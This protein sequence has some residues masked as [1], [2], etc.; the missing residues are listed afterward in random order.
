MGG[1]DYEKNK[2]TILALAVGFV[3]MGVP[4]KADDY[5]VMGVQ[6]AKTAK[7]GGFTTLTLESFGNYD[8][9]GADNVRYAEKELTLGLVKEKGLELLGRGQVKGVNCDAPVALKAG[10]STPSQVLSKTIEKSVSAYS[11]SAINF[12]KRTFKLVKK[13]DPVLVAALEGMLSTSYNTAVKNYAGDRPMEIG[14]TYS[15]APT[16]AVY[17]FSEI[18][19]SCIMQ[20][21]YASR[22]GPKICGDFF[23]A[24]DVK[25]KRALPVLLTMI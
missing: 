1:K 14:F 15:L 11:A 8:G 4:L 9:T 12:E 16:G 17:P 22:N 2:F 25:I 13:P 23:R 20:E 7:A 5:L 21:T 3:F 24:L 18:E 10:Y 6:L 19:V